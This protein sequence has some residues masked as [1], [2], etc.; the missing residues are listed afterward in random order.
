MAARIPHDAIPSDELNNGTTQ[1]WY[2]YIE[3]YIKT[4]EMYNEDN[5]VL[6]EDFIQLDL[7]NHCNI[8]KSILH[9]LHKT[10]SYLDKG[11]PATEIF[12]QLSTILHI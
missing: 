5:A 2:P 9:E 3:E 11:T 12:H 4:K 10:Y 7:Y 1:R 6:W 8:H